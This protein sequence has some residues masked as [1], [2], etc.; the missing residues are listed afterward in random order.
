MAD[1]G[2]ESPLLLAGKNAPTES[3][4]GGKHVSSAKKGRPPQGRPRAREDRSS[5]RRRRGSRR[6]AQGRRSRGAGRPPGRGGAKAVRVE[7]GVERKDVW[8]VLDAE[9]GDRAWEPDLSEHERAISGGDAFNAEWGGARCPGHPACRGCERTAHA[10][11]SC[12][13]TADA[14]PEASGR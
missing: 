10:Q 6:T 5:G 4:R 2:A 13:R 8:K 9:R 3:A 1:T 11:R 14:D 12:G 7:W